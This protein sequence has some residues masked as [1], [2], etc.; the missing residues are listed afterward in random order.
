MP[1]RRLLAALVLV[2]SVLVPSFLITSAGSASAHGGEVRSALIEQ[3]PPTTEA[4]PPATAVDEP[5]RL[6]DEAGDGTDDGPPTGMLVGLA[7]GALGL[8]V[9]GAVLIRQ[10]AEPRRR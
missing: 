1:V 8:I 5:G 3:V 2:A 6:V 4:P 7:I 10:R 9:G